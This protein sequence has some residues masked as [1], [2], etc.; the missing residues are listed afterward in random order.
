MAVDT[1]IICVLLGA[2][3]ALQSWMLREITR[4]KVRVAVLSA[5][6]KAAHPKLA[7]DDEPESDT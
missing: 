6:H 3:L 7:T 5:L 1:S 2:V 4:L